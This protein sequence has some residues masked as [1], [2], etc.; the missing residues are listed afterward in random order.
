M[1]DNFEYNFIFLLNLKTSS[2]R[3]IEKN[4]QI[5]PSNY[6]HSLTA[7]YEILS[8]SIN[9]A[10]KVSKMYPKYPPIHENFNYVVDHKSNLGINL[11]V[12]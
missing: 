5:K 7:P 6:T 9:H 2:E 11:I 1:K 3:K 12:Q 4:V 8:I 10:T